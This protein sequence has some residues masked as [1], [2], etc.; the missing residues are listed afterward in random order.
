M[1]AVNYTMSIL[2]I[3]NQ[4]TTKTCQRHSNFGSLTKVYNKDYIGNFEY[5]QRSGKATLTFENN[6]SFTGTFEA[7]RAHGEGVF[8]GKSRTVHGIWQNDQL[9]SLL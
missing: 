5:D 3:H 1:A 4:S 9:K 8:R 6:E 7:D 2:G